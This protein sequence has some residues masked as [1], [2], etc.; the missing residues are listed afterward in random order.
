LVSE[1]I[2]ELFEIA[3]R[4]MVL[5]QG[6]MSPSVTT[7]K[8]TVEQLGLWMSGL[9]PRGGDATKVDHAPH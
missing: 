4:L 9:W 6:E 5:S 8:A 1:E 7:E 3:D 2:D